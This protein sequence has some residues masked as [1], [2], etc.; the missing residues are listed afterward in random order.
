MKRSLEEETEKVGNVVDVG[1]ESVQSPVIDWTQQDRQ[2]GWQDGELVQPVEDPDWDEF[3]L[4]SRRR[5]QRLVTPEK[6]KC[7]KEE[8]PEV[9]GAPVK[10][11]S[12]VLPWTKEG[13]EKWP[14]ASTYHL[15]SDR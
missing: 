13:Q 10:K 12:R 14:S 9:P 6:Q 15:F 7:G 8:L 2:P 1:T 4:S 11:K 5:Q 3:I